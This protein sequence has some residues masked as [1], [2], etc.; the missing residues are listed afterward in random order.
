M[1]FE[2][3]GSYKIV[4]VLNGQRRTLKWFAPINLLEWRR[5]TQNVKTDGTLRECESFMRRVIAAADVTTGNPVDGYFR[6]NAHYGRWFDQ[7]KLLR[8]V[9]GLK[10]TDPLIGEVTL[11]LIHCE[12][13]RLV[14]EHHIS[15]DLTNQKPFERHPKARGN[16]RR[17]NGVT[18]KVNDVESGMSYQRDRAL[19]PSSPIAFLGFGSAYSSFFRTNNMARVSDVISQTRSQF[20]NLVGYDVAQTIFKMADLDILETRLAEHG[21]RFRYMTE[22]LHDN[23]LAWLKNL[24][25]IHSMLASSIEIYRAHLEVISELALNPVHINMATATYDAVRLARLGDDPAALLAAETTQQTYS[26]LL[27]TIKLTHPLNKDK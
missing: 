12:S 21:M 11:R 13:S 7:I 17:A 8:F 27:A 2:D 25:P 16:T 15:L 24:K 6:N 10:P 26:D 1:N 3:T 22:P 5:K 9:F 23:G 4:R 19:K 14:V 20:G 18:R